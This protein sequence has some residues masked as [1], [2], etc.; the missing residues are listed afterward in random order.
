MSWGKVIIFYYSIFCLLFLYFSCQMHSLFNRGEIK[1]YWHYMPDYI[2][3]MGKKVFYYSIS[4]P[5]FLYFSCQMLSLFNRREINLYW[6]CRPNYIESIGNSFVTFYKGI[7][8]LPFF[9]W[10]RGNIE[11]N[12]NSFTH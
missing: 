12:V 9:F 6:D 11:V 2:K 10:L 3:S 4:C 5:L 8:E 1:L 7:M